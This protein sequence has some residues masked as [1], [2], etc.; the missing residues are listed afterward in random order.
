MCDLRNDE[1]T[2]CTNRKKNYRAGRTW[3]F[4]CVGPQSENI[5]DSLLAC[6]MEKKRVDIPDMYFEE[7][8]NKDE[9]T[10]RGSSGQFNRFTYSETIQFSCCKTELM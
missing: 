2:I 6:E 4:K 10:S 7:K 8:L 9:M 5:I 1:F 3:T